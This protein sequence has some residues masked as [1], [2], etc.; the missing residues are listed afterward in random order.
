MLCDVCNHGMRE[1]DHVN[2]GNSVFRTYQ[3]TWC[4]NRSTKCEG[5]SNLSTI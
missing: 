3:C 2:S 1:V 5:L 4:S